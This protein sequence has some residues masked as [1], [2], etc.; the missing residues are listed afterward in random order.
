MAEL[1]VRLDAHLTR[2]E[3]EPI[4]SGQVAPVTG[5]LGAA[6]RRLVA[7]EIA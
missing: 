3:G 1:I 4:G 7:E 6:Y 5:R 2:F